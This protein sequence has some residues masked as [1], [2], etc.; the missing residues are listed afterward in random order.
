LWRLRFILLMSAYLGQRALIFLIQLYR[1]RFSGKGLLKGVACTFCQC[2]SCSAYGLR[3]AQ[4][5]DRLLDV[6]SQIRARLRRCGEASLF[7]AQDAL[8]WGELY[9]QDPKQLEEMLLA[10]K[11]SPATMHAALLHAARVA[12]F[13]RDHARSRMLAQR[14]AQY[15]AQGELLVRRGDG[16]TL[17]LYRRLWYFLCWPLLLL[18]AGAISS[19]F[20]GWMLPISAVSS[21]LWSSQILSRYLKKKRHFE[22]QLVRIQFLPS[23]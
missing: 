1:R 3:V 15:P 23:R 6:V 21:L 20:W 16:L 8:L 4:T 5:G 14:A 10:A 19:F 11:E 13:Q 22:A 9:E 17:A 7:R 2:E 12:K 18:A